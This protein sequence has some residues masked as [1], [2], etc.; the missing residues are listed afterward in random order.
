MSPRARAAL[1]LL[2]LVALLS[3]AGWFLARGE[4]DTPREFV[5]RAMGLR[6]AWWAPAAFVVVYA[7]LATLDFS[8]LVLT[9]AGG[10]LFGLGWGVVINTLGANL[11]ASGGFWLARAFGRDGVRGLVGRRLAAVDRVVETGGFLWLLRLRLVPV[12][13]F[14]LLNLAAGLTAIQWSTFAAVTALGI[15]PGTI[16]YTWFANAL[17]AG[18]REASRDAVLRVGLASG[19]LILLSFAPWIV[20][21]LRRAPL[22]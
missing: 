13:P 9:L 11:G 4:I 16:I 7:V 21:R 12:V 20:R 2:A 14:N 1:K 8:G 17:V 3:L 15:L 5:E 10:A 6:D 22:P 19:A 18:S